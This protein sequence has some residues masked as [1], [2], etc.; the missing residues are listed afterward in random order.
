M[1]RSLEVPLFVAICLGS[2]PAAAAEAR[3]AAPTLQIDSDFPGGNIVLEKIEGDS[4]YLH[5]DL[6][7]SRGPWFYWAFRVRHAAGRTLTFRFTR[8]AVLGLRG[9]A[10]STDAGK[11]WSW[12]GAGARGDSF[13]YAFPADAGQARFSFGIPYH[14]ANLQQFLKRHKDHPAV[15]VETLCK[16]EKG[17]PVEAIF[18]GGLDGRA[19]YRLLFTCRHHACEALASYCVEG[20]MTAA[21]ADND[22][23]RWLRAHVEALIVPFMD[24]DGVEEGDQG[25]N[26]K[27]HDHWLDYAGTS[28]YASV[29]ALRQRATTWA[30]RRLDVALDFHCPA[31]LDDRIYLAGSPTPK[32]AES[33]V[34]LCRILESSQR[35]P[36]VFR[37]EDNMPF[38][39]GWNTPATYGQRKSFAL[40]AEELP[41]VRIAATVEVPYAS[42]RGAPV[43]ADAARAIGASMARALRQFLEERN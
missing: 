11:T 28:R 5:H 38:G 7:D 27:P 33:T 35:G 40:W 31:R 2:C 29:A 41:R 14:E 20:F 17:R 32:I 34:R 16:T 26:R 22:D 43:T 4:V 24:K 23:G 39:K 10:V 12:L 9:P 15:R 30:G 42:V 1:C 6:R 13:S 25:K 18:L 37:S 3:V 21:L 8:G 36:L 19:D